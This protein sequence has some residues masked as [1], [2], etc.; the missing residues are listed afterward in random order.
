MCSERIVWI[1]DGLE[2]L[3]LLLILK[4]TWIMS[5]KSLCKHEYNYQC[6]IFFGINHCIIKLVFCLLCSV[7]RVIFMY[8]ERLNIIFCKCVLKSSKQYYEIISKPH[9]CLLDHVIPILCEHQHQK[10]YLCER[11]QL[12]E[13]LNIL[14]L[15]IRSRSGQL[16]SK[17]QVLSIFTTNTMFW[18]L[19]PCWIVRPSE[20]ERSN[21]YL[22]S[23]Y[24]FWN[25]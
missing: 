11:W 4:E 22:L 19:P 25:K 6:F 10:T 3:H 17:T 12:L 1:V 5:I 24:R 23:Q 14:F 2:V 13:S 7:F 8:F 16:I 9:H 18:S 20:A 21:T 15:W